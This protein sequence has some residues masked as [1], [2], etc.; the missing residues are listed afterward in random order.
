[1]EQGN[2]DE[3]MAK[4]GLYYSLYMAQYK[5]RISEVLDDIIA[6]NERKEKTAGQ[7][8]A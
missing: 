3:L 6:A 2:H 1:V 5:G 7:K 4:R 8:P